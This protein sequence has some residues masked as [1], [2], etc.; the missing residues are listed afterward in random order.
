MAIQQKFAFPV[1]VSSSACSLALR[2][3]RRDGKL[4]AFVIG[5]G[6]ILLYW[7]IH[8]L[9]DAMARGQLL[10]AVWAAG[11]RRSSLARSLSPPWSGRP[12]IE[13][14][15]R[16]AASSRQSGTGVPVA[17]ACAAHD[18]P[19]PRT[20][21]TSR[22]VLVVRVRASRCRSRHSRPYVTGIYLRVAALTFVGLSVSSTS[23]TS[24][25]AR[26]HLQRPDDGSMLFAYYWYASPQFVYYVLP[27]SVLIAT[28]VTIGVL[29][30]RASSRSSR[31]AV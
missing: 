12:L 31:P 28:L 3:L 1:A 4:A 11:S 16:S 19:R 15:C 21:A 20:S 25:I 14:T 24:S 10:P 29:T 27:L 13:G 5:M 9:A 22:V 26:L 23:R 8:I 30:R 18:V 7:A 6:V 17:G 2:H